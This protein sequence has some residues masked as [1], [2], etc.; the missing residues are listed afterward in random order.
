MQIHKYIGT[1]KSYKQ[2]NIFYYDNFSQWPTS[3]RNHKYCGKTRSKR[4]ARR[5]NLSL[6]CLDIRELKDYD[7][8][9]LKKSTNV[10]SSTTE[11]R[12]FQAALILRINIHLISRMEASFDGK[13]HSF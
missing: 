6:L 5:K 8:F 2:T 10:L 9:R 1:T 3:K 11:L 13:L 4:V 12:V 7:F